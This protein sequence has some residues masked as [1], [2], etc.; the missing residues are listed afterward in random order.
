MPVSSP[1]EQVVRQ[2]R[3]NT[4]D[5]YRWTRRGRSPDSSETR[6]HHGGGESPADEPLFVPAAHRNTQEAPRLPEGRGVG[7]RSARAVRPGPRRRPLYLPEYDYIALVGRHRPLLPRHL[8]STASLTLELDNLGIPQHTAIDFID[9][10]PGLRRV[11]DRWVRWGP[12][13][14]NGPKPPCTYP[15]YRPRPY[16]SPPPSATLQ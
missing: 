11:G 9:S 15:A 2:G 10:R 3:W 6:L 7:E 5:T 14:A 1:P 12:T 4:E 16:S 13:I 8:R